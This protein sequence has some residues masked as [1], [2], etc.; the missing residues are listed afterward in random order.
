M[1]LV[2]IVGESVIT[3]NLNEIFILLYYYFCFYNIFKLDIYKN[4][5]FTLSVC[6]FRTCLGASAS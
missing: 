4:R 1:V 2:N 3:I 5:L 6:R